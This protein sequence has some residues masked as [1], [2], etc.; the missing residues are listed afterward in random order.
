MLWNRLANTHDFSLLCGYAMGNFY[1]EKHGVDFVALNPLH[2]LGN[3]GHA[4]APYSPTWPTRR[5]VRPYR[6]THRL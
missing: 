1:K 5:T 2:A 6:P 4:I 3:R